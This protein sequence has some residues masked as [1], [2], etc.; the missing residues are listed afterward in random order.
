MLIYKYVAAP[1]V[2]DMMQYG[3]KKKNKITR[4]YIIRQ[5]LV[6]YININNI[7]K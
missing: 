1:P 3:S 4:F 7:Y 2:S 6:Y 5:L